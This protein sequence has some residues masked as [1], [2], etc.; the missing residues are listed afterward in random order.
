MVYFTDVA[1]ETNKEQNEASLENAA[2]K[3]C[4]ET[5]FNVMCNM[6][7]LAH[8]VGPRWRPMLAR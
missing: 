1:N 2:V 6:I 5:A 8:Y 4:L 3:V 7:C